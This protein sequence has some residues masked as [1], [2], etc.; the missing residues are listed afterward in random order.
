M[1]LNP[2]FP[3]SLT[4]A[5]VIDERLSAD[6]RGKLLASHPS[7]DAELWVC[8]LEK[9]VAAH[10]GGWDKIDGGTCTHGW[11]LLTG[12][13]DQYTIRC[14]ADGCSCFG[15]KNPNTNTWEKLGNSPHDGSQRVWPMDW[16]A[17]GG[18]GGL[19]TR[20][21]IRSGRGLRPHT[22]PSHPQQTR[23]LASL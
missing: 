13:M 1:A 18:G 15:T 22:L 17:V 7:V 4:S 5:L 21:T 14:K 10:C 3:V 23:P 19:R 12:C 6:E 2:I 11:R 16:P 8:Y 9:A 20:N